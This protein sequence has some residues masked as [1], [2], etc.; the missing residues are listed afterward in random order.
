MSARTRPEGLGLI[1]NSLRTNKAPEKS[2]KWTH[3]KS[4]LG[5]RQLREG[6]TKGDA[7]GRARSGFEEKG[8]A[9]K[10]GSSDG[11]GGGALLGP[12]DPYGVVVAKGGGGEAKC[13]DLS[14]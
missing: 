11:K 7:D 1:K 8:D 5:V 4:Y 3:R 14:A 12:N 10:W 2:E 6:K 13:G 9:D